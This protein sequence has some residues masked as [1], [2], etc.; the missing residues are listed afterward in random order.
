MCCCNKTVRSSYQKCY[1]PSCSKVSG[2]P[3]A[4]TSS[5]RPHLIIYSPGVAR[6]QNKDKTRQQPKTRTRQQTKPRTRQQ[7]Q[8]FASLPPTTGS[9][10]A[11]F[12]SEHQNGQYRKVIGRYGHGRCRWDCIDC[13][14]H[15]RG[16]RCDCILHLP[17]AFDE[18]VVDAR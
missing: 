15:G 9:K 18:N 5:L 12:I 2:C 14:G 11:F 4:H 13:I 1:T 16:R 3:N 17:R 8:E 7:Q 6:N 10:G